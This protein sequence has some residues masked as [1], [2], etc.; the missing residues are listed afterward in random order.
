ML[1]ERCWD[2]QAAFRLVLGPLSLSRFRDFLPGD[3]AFAPLLELTRFAT[4]TTLDFDVQLILKA[5]E[6]P[7]CRLERPSSGSARLGWS[8]WLKT[9]EFARDAADAV[10]GRH[11][12]QVPRRPARFEAAQ[13]GP[14]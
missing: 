7:A 6:V 11:L 14:A 9:R 13:P 12:M 2:Q 10:L 3:G 4:G 1:G 5:A 8:S